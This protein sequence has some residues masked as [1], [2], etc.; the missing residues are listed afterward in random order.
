MYEFI[1]LAS[2]PETQASGNRF[3][4]P[5][6]HTAVGFLDSPQFPSIRPKCFGCFQPL[7]IAEIGRHI[8][9]CDR[10]SF[11]DLARF[12]TA[13]DEFKANPSRAREVFEEFVNRFRSNRRF[14]V[15]NSAS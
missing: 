6:K 8:L 2:E 11:Q 5:R 13:Q 1:R 14:D 3:G 9:S 12:K 15:E 4:P 10:V 7:V